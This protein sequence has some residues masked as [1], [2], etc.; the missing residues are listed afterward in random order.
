MELE[1]KG[2]IIQILPL[3]SGTGRNGTWKKQSFIIETF[4]KFPKKICF[5]LWNEKTDNFESLYPVNSIVSVSFNLESREFNGSWYTDARAWRISPANAQQPEQATPPQ[6]TG[7]PVSS[8]ALPP[9]PV[10][11]FPLDNDDLPF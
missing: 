2:K 9:E 11:E 8:S 7:T 3:Q 4:D 1:V 6:N 10:E 5:Q